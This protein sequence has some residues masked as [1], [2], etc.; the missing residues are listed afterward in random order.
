MIAFEENMCIAA[1]EII[2]I[3]R[4]YCAEIVDHMFHDLYHL[5][6]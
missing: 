2:I 3:Q 5:A 1:L 4:L 6:I